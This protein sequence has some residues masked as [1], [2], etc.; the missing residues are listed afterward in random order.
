MMMGRMVKADVSPTDCPLCNP[1]QL[2]Q[3]F[4]TTV[5][6]HSKKGIF[7]SLAGLPRAPSYFFVHVLFFRLEA[8]KFVYR[9]SWFITRYND[10]YDCSGAGEEDWCLD[11]INA[12]FLPN[13][14][15]LSS[16]GH[17]YNQL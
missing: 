14:A 6:Q 1:Q 3:Q 8:A 2:G 12:L 11:K 16:L 15:E 5:N 9:Y 4:C 7:R 10:K 13:S 17:L